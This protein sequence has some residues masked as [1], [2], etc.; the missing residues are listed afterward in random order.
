[1]EPAEI[2][3]PGIVYSVTV[4]YQR[5]LPQLEVPFGL[6]LVDFPD[7]PGVRVVGRLRGCAPQDAVIGMA[8]AV[9]F[10][11][12]PGG[13]FIP[14]FRAIEGDEPP[15]GAAAAGGPGAGAAGSPGAASKAPRP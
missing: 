9:G 3:E 15:A 2:T 1:M 5:W 14:S 4:N 7:H 6:V 8:V 10:E 13:F 12:G 11:P